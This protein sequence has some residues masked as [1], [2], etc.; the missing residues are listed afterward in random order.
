MKEFSLDEYVIWVEFDEN[1]SDFLEKKCKE[2]DDNCIPEGIR[3]PHMTITFVKTAFENKLIEYVERFMKTHSV[4]MKLNSIGAF[5]GGVLFYEPKADEGLLR[6]QREFCEG[7]SEFAELS[8][9]LYYPGNW[10]PHIALTGLLDEE[11]A[12][13]AFKI[14][15][16]DY[17]PGKLV[18]KKVLI[19]NS[20]GDTV[21]DLDI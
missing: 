11:K 7:V 18:I 20:T 15:L 2:L 10:T 12:A 17:N 13:R 16:R 3:P 9:D 4:D 19:R 21:L 8:W 14:M 6:F 1:T 5:V